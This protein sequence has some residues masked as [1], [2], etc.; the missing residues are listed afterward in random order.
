MDESSMSEDPEDRCRQYK[1]VETF[2]STLCHP[3]YAAQSQLEAQQKTIED[4]KRRLE[5]L[6]V[7]QTE[8]LILASR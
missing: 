8:R 7:V 2:L 5:A 3:R 6:E 1:I 4:M